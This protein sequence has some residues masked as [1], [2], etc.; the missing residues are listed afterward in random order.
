MKRGSLPGFM[1]YL[2]DDVGVSEATARTYVGYLRSASR[3][4]SNP[5]D[6]LDSEITSTTRGAAY[7][8][9]KHWARYTDD[10]EALA[11]LEHPSMLRTL[12]GRGRR[13]GRVTRPLDADDFEA[14]NKAL[15]KLR[16]KRPGWAWPCIV[17]LLRLGLRIRVDLLGLQ[18]HELQAAMTSNRLTFQTKRGKVRTVPLAPAKEAAKALLALG[19]WVDVGGLIAGAE[20]GATATDLDKAY[21]L[22][23]EVI[24]QVAKSAGIDPRSVHP[25]RLRHTAATALWTATKDILKV[26]DFLGHSNVSTTE[27]Y[28]RG[29]RTDEIGDDLMEIYK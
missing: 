16:G 5:L 2:L 24:Q 23:R 15:E 29:D 19:G 17:I 28:L 13:P 27:R 20:G 1:R 3:Q 10:E 14:F 6:Y 7:T 26:R 21:L 8:A 25:H 18:R 4:Y 22:L 12:R 9:L 11:K